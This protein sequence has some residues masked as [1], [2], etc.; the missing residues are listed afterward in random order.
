MR[1][2]DFSRFS[3]SAALF[4]FAFAATATAL[5]TEDGVD[6]CGDAYEQVDDVFHDCPLS[7]EQVYQVKVG[8]DKTAKT[9]QAPI[10]RTYGNKDTANHCQRI[11]LHHTL[12]VK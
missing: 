10:K 1:F 5:E 12:W 6:D 11:F 7:E 4:A 8:V 3:Q 9:D 2:L